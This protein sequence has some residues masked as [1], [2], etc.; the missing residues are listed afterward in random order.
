MPR[1]TPTPPRRSSDAVNSSA[2][3]ISLNFH[4]QHLARWVTVHTGSQRAMKWAA[5][6]LA[7][8]LVAASCT[9]GDGPESIP[10]PTSP[11]TTTTTTTTT[12][13]TTTTTT[14]TTLA[15]PTYEATIRRTTDGVPHISGRD[16]ADLAF[17]QGY[18]SGGDYGCTLLDQVIKVRGE[19]SKAF[20]PGTNGENVTSDFGWRAI[21]VI[22]VAATDWESAAPSVVEQFEGFASGWNQHLDDQGND[23]LTGWCEGADWIR[24]IEPV[25]VYAY[26]RSVALLA[27]GESFVD[28]IAA[29]L[30][31]T[32]PDDGDASSPSPPR[33]PVSGDVDF[34]LLRPVDVGSNAWA[35][36]S[37]RT[38]TGEGSILVANPHFPWEGE[39][40]FA[41]FHLTVPGEI[42]VYGAQLAG[43]PGV[44][45]GFTDGVAWSHTASAGHRFTAYTLDLDPVSPTSYLVDG[46]PQAMIATDHTV[47]ILRADGTVDTETRTLHRTE[48]GPV[49]D[50][51]GVGWTDERVLTYRDANID[52]D[53]FL[54]LYDDLLDV[55]DLDD[56][57]ETHARHQGVPLFNTVAVGADGGTWYADTSATP[58]LSDEAQ[59]LLLQ[60]R[61]DDVG[62]T[63]LAFDQGVVLLDGSD[64]RFRWE[65]VDGARDPGLVPFD[66]QPQVERTDYVFN[67]N[68][69][70]W[71]PSDEF[72][73]DGDFSVLH[74]ERE[75][76]QSMRTRQNIAALSNTN[77]LGLS[78]PDGL[79]DADEARTATFD[80]TAQTALLLRAPVAGACAANP[81]VD[82]GDLVVDEVIVLAAQTV[83]LTGACTVL[84]GW[85]G[86]FDLESAGALLWREF[87]QQF[88][89]AALRS[90]GQLFSEPFDP[91]RPTQTPAGFVEDPSDVLQALARAVQ[92]VTIAGFAT[93]STLGSAQ[94][95]ERSGER[96]ALHGGTGRE[97]VTNVVEWSDDNSSNEPAPVR[98]E[99]VVPGAALRSVGSPV[100]FGTSFVLTVDFSNGAPEASAIL[101]YGQSANRS[102]DMFSSQM[103]RFSEKAWRTVAFT[104]EAIEADPR[105]DTTVVVQ[106]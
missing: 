20:G 94:F 73:L 46:E 40:R 83:D 60:R 59:Q 75:V 32:D 101:T 3:T 105:L 28:F 104:E 9:P 18:V 31:P 89:D 81:A 69:S 51:P 47:E 50:F 8:A 49:I 15:P 26:A 78:G 86:R 44:G 71:I 99:P 85:D 12:V 74:G 22:G 70:Y 33:T 82:V 37:D 79:F 53:E 64:S 56:L 14:S 61:L 23:G 102:S 39:L 29:A 84:S 11:D 103:V 10:L 36:G 2:S 77:P 90:S 80:N 6:A 35:I 17:G 30:P 66:A 43:L 97:G 42:N 21:D 63:N 57:R 7:T 65:E 62:L 54:E 76:A 16:R 67:A 45:I 87:I 96:I 92:I 98:E 24:P 34:S 19:R 58:N 1:A 68:D 95:T 25:E 38:A 106:P 93:D 88:P 27:S 52:N 5:A 55:T 41:E 48:Y 100:N 91:V 72:T 4:S 13:A